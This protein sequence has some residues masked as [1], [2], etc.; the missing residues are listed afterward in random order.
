MADKISERR[1]SAS[2]FFLTVKTALIAFLG[3]VASPNVGDDTGLGASP[4][5]PQG[6]VVSAAG[7]CCA[8]PGIG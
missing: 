7:W 2:S 1:Q 8:T 5:L 4:P 6:L 3:F